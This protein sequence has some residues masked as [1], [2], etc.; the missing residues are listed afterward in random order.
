M[1][2]G[3]GREQGQGAV[4]GG[5]KEKKTGQKRALIKRSKKGLKMFCFAFLLLRHCFASS[6]FFSIAI[7]K[8]N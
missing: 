2:V 3:Q 5:A 4:A 1:G 8:Q 7:R 6:N